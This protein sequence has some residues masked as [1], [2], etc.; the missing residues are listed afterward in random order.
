LSA[1]R[2]FAALS[3]ATRR[4]I[5]E[6][7]REHEELAAGEIAGRFPR[8]SR[9]AV[10]KHLRVLRESGLVRAEERGREN[11]YRLDAAPLAEVQRDWLDG[12]APLWEQSLERLK[13][14]AERPRPPGAR[15]GSHRRRSR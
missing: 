12:F 8:I 5:L 2:T 13:V 14:A 15:P 7:L 4:A 9:P 10:S 6:L 11:L 1:D 3:D